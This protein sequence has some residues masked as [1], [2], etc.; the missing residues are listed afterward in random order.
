MKKT[1]LRLAV[2]FAFGLPGF[3]Q[4]NFD[5]TKL[6]N[7]FNTLEQNNKFMGSVAVSK[8]GEIIFSRSINQ[9]PKRIIQL[10]WAQGQ[11]PLHQLT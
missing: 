3:G 8:N 9:R 7:Y 1:I 2:L 6:H 5:V 10:H 11:L 4:S